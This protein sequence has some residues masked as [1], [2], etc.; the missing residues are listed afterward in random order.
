MN[1][2]EK[3]ILDKIINNNV[4]VGEQ[5]SALL[6]HTILFMLGWV[7]GVVDFSNFYSDI[8]A[9]IQLAIFILIVLFPFITLFSAFK[10]A[11]NNEGINFIS[12]FIVLSSISL[13]K[14]L[15][16]FA[17]VIVAYVVAYTL[18]KEFLDI[19]YY[20]VQYYFSITII[21]IIQMLY[22]KKMMRFFNYIYGGKGE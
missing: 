10:K 1:S 13:K 7:T 22:H 19:V 17:F 3:V 6:F 9:I 5:K 4:S 8:P 21:L 18:L 16:S 20:D 15:I 14:I 12:S 11:K 2:R